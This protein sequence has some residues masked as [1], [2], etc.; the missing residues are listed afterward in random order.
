VHVENPIVSGWVD[1]LR[2]RPGALDRHH[3]AK[4]GPGEPLDRDMVQVIPLMDAVRPEEARMP[5][6]K[7]DRR[8]DFGP[9]TRLI[10]RRAHAIVPALLRTLLRRFEVGNRRLVNRALRVIASDVIAKKV[11]KSAVLAVE[12]D[13]VARGLL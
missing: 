7:L 13:L 10:E 12:R 11:G 9:V 6:P 1:R 8:N 3:P 2:C 4:V 5:W